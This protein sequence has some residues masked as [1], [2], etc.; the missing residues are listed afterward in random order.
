[1][2]Q[3]FLNLEFE[4]ETDKKLIDCV[5]LSEAVIFFGENGK[6]RKDLTDTSKFIAS[7][8]YGK[9][10]VYKT[11]QGHPL[12]IYS[13]STNFPYII[14]NYTGKILLPNCSRS[15]Y[16][17]YTIDNG[18]QGRRVYSHR[19]FAMAFIDNFHP[20]I[21]YNVNHINEDKLDYRIDNM[22]WVSTSKNMKNIKNTANNKN[23]NF[24][25]YSSENYI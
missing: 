8:P 15:V 12:P 9:Y 13:G 7:V 11:G 16:P 25:F 23:N 10:T 22:D 6:R 14:N 3:T 18:I 20:E 4:K 2:T 24:K 17:C 1:M 5:D 21:N 19:I